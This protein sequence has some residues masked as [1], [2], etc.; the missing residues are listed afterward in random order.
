MASLFKLT[1][2]PTYPQLSIG[3]VVEDYQLKERVTP[4][5]S[6]AGF[7]GDPVEP[8]VEHSPVPIF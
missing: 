5:S 8:F 2:T 4:A 7:I 3:Y 1:S 6:G